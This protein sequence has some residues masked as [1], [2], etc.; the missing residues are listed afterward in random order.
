MEREISEKL[1]RPRV[2]KNFHRSL[3]VLLSATLLTASL[4][5]ALLIKPQFSYPHGQVIGIEHSIKHLC[6]EKACEFELGFLTTVRDK[7]DDKSAMFQWYLDNMVEWKAQIGILRVIFYYN[8][9]Y[10]ETPDGWTIMG[11]L[12]RVRINKKQL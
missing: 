2:R 7:N 1:A 4:I 9:A 6:Y 5:S 8:A 11:P 3:V 10:L 12:F